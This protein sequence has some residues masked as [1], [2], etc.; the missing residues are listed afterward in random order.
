MPTDEDANLKRAIL[1]LIF[2][3]D[4]STLKSTLRI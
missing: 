4:T 3:D 1:E 2:I